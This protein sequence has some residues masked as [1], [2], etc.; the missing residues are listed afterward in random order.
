VDAHQQERRLSS[1]ELF[2][3]ARP[4]HRRP[5]EEAFAITNAIKRRHE[6]M[7]DVEI[8]RAKYFLSVNNTHGAREALKEELRHFPDNT[9]AAAMFQQ[10]GGDALK[11][12]VAKNDA[13]KELIDLFNRVRPFN[14]LRHPAARCCMTS[15]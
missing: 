12:H 10:L 13:E 7:R 5:D 6:R 11:P 9:Q 2:A 8:I 4:V 1:E 15:P 14:R 3:K